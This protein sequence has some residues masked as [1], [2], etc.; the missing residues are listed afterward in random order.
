MEKG[1]VPRQTAARDSAL[2]T[3]VDNAPAKRGP[4]SSRDED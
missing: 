1:E 3:S 4:L 2:F